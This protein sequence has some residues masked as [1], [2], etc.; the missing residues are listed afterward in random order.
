MGEQF[1]VAN[2]SPIRLSLSVEIPRVF[3]ES[4]S[5]LMK[6]AIKPAA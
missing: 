2:M 5:L 6:L 3:G 1:I 4:L